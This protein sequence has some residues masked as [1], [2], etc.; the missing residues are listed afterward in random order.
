LIV[1]DDGTRA[2]LEVTT[3]TDHGAHEVEIL[4]AADGGDEPRVGPVAAIT[5]ETSGLP[6]RNRL[7]KD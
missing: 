6:A 4:L 3:L 2:A 1:Y 7:A 5:C